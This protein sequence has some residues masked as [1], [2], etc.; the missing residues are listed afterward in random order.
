MEGIELFQSGQVDYLLCTD[1]VARGLDIPAVKAVLNFS[2]P[3][4]PKRYLHRIGR[5][6]RAGSHGVAVTL[7]NDEE[8]K[9]IKKLLRKL[10][11]NINTYVV[12]AKQ[13]TETHDFIA[14][15]L[16]PIIHELDLEIQA[17]K[18]IEAAY[19][20]ALRAENLVKFK[21]DIMSRPKAEWHS[22]KKQ[23]TELKKESKKD[24]KNIRSNFEGHVASQPRKRD[25]KKEQ[26]QLAKDKSG[27]KFTD[28]AETDKT[29]FKKKK[30]QDIRSGNNKHGK[31]GQTHS[32]KHGQPD[33][34]D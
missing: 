27:S 21:K 4:E 3:V 2:F 19:K 26:K 28:D 12:S 5:T 9:D 17:D 18:E 34:K 30:S 10:N 20:E 29:A 31:H 11:Q 14:N 13:V 33:G 25:V 22:T 15:K 23:A 16:D 6:A 1:L 8:R 32:N 7:C 24:L